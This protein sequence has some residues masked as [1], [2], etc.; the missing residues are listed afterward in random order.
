VWIRKY[1]VQVDRDAELCAIRLY[2]ENNELKLE[3]GKDANCDWFHI[4][5][6]RNERVLGIKAARFNQTEGRLMDP[7][8]VIG[9]LE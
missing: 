3:A 1:S 6:Q 2:D 4:T 8:F 7:I 5:L 9:R